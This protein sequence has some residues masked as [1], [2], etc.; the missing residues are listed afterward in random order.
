MWAVFA[1]S[2]LALGCDGPAD[3]EAAPVAIR[4]S[5]ESLDLDEGAS[6]QLSATVLD[7]QGQ[8]ISN[9]PVRWSSSDTLVASVNESGAVSAKEPGTAQVTASVP[10]NGPPL[11]G[12]VTVTVHSVPVSIQ[13]VP[14]KNFGRAG[15]P[16]DPPIRFRVVDRRGNGVDGVRVNFA[17]VS[18]GGSLSVPE[19]VTDAEGYASV[20]L[21]FG[22]GPGLTQVDA[23]IDGGKSFAQFFGTAQPWLTFEPESLELPAGCQGKLFARRRYPNGMELLG[24]IVPYS[25]SDSTLAHLEFIPGGGTY[26]ANYGGATRAVLA[27][28]PG[29]V[30]VIAEHGGIADTA[31]LRITPNP[32]I[33]INFVS[34]RSVA[35]ATGDTTTNYVALPT[36]CRGYITS[37]GPPTNFRSLNER[38]VVASRGSG[39]HV[40]RVVARAAGRAVVVAEYEGAT[41]TLAVDVRDLRLSPADT[42]VF[43]GDTITYRASSAGSDGVFSPERIRAVQT[44]D[45]AVASPTGGSIVWWGGRSVSMA[46]SAETPVRVVARGTGTVTLGLSVLSRNRPVIV[47]VLPKP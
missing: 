43:V 36:S 1:T 13:L 41:D 38:V 28:H 23:R 29:S 7:A 27:W 15:M 3:P 6:G 12:S 26:N 11:T 30:L 17:L 31:R 10:R 4:L 18:G 46:F 40:V 22:T 47:R 25:I 34:F 33:R 8:V 42:T 19:A 24:N 5:A 2:L 45:T 20:V 35:L 21:T 37:G 14:G 39:Q 32:A 44:P 16:L 9:A